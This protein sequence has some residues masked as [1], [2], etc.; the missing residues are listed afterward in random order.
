MTYELLIGLLVTDVIIFAL[1]WLVASKNHKKQLAEVLQ[2]HKE[3]LVRIQKY[4]N[5]RY[6]S[7]LSIAAKTTTREPIVDS[8]PRVNKSKKAW[9]PVV[10]IGD[11]ALPFLSLKRVPWSVKIEAP[12]S[13]EKI[14]WTC[15]FTI[16]EPTPTQPKEQATHGYD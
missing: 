8:P 14:I 12:P 5:Q 7:L 6:S 16:A 10:Y 11:L 1:G 13:T 4:H 9:P 2:R 15:S 3:T